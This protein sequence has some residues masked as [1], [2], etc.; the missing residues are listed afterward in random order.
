MHDIQQLQPKIGGV[1]ICRTS[2]N[3]SRPVKE[4]MLKACKMLL[5]QDRHGLPVFEQ[6]F[7]TSLV[8]F[9]AAS[10]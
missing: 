1:L 5:Q 8:N 3:L 2:E 9:E 4:E 7:F 6:R 10:G